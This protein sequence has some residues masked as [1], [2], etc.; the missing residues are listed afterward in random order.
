MKTKKFEFDGLPELCKWLYV[1]DICRCKCD[2]CS[3]DSMKYD[4]DKGTLKFECKIEV[5]I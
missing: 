5:K 3:M 1:N 2:E 4:M